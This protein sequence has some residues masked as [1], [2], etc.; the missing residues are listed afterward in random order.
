MC[1]AAEGQSSRL[2]SRGRAARGWFGV[3]RA[4]DDATPQRVLHAAQIRS[5]DRSQ[6]SSSEPARADS[7][8]EGGLAGRACR[9]NRSPALLLIA[10]RQPESG[11]LIMTRREGE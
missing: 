10:A 5:Q 3:Y 6:I 4:C 1:G 7:K 2:S 9:A 8:V 11:E